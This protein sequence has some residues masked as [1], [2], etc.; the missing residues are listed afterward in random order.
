MKEKYTLV[1]DKKKYDLMNEEPVI[2]T[3]KGNWV[4]VFSPDI[5]TF[6]IEDIAHALSHQCRSSGH[7]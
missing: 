6:D 4:N 7:P 3:F 2:R 1:A 5:D